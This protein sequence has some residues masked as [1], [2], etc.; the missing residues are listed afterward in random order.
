MNSFLRLRMWNEVR[1]AAMR[2]ARTLYL[3]VLVLAMGVLPG[4]GSH[5]MFSQNP[6][7][8]SV[9]E[10]SQH[11]AQSEHRWQGCYRHSS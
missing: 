3:S 9:A 5:T 11:E 7:S 1:R 6:G 10:E 8:P 4:Q 2:M